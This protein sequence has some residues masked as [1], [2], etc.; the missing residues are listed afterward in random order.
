M[1]KRTRLE[2]QVD[3]EIIREGNIH[4]DMR[5]AIRVPAQPKKLISLRVPMHLLT[6]LKQEAAQSH[7]HYQSLILHYIR[8]GL[9]RD[10]TGT[11]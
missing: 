1:R 5:D 8:E 10:G 11:G 2:R 3:L 6:R 4:V 9:K 7:G